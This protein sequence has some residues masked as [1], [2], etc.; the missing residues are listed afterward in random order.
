[1]EKNNLTNKD[2]PQ[3]KLQEQIMDFWSVRGYPVVKAVLGNLSVSFHRNHPRYEQNGLCYIYLEQF[4]NQ[5]QQDILVKVEKVIEA[6]IN[7][8]NERDLKIKNY[9]LKKLKLNG[10]KQK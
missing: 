3:T 6:A 2:F 9:I 10:E 8:G 1:M 5:A 4:Y 7:H